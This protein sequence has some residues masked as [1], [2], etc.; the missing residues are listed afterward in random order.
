MEGEWSTQDVRERASWPTQVLLQTPPRAR[1][2]PDTKQ[3]NDGRRCYRCFF[4]T[5]DNL[6]DN[7]QQQRW[8]LKP[9][10]FENFDNDTKR[11]LDEKRKVLRWVVDKVPDLQDIEYC[12]AVVV[13][14][15]KDTL[16]EYKFLEDS[17]P[18]ENELLKLEKLRAENLSD[19]EK[20]T[21]CNQA[22]RL[23]EKLD[24]IFAESLQIGK[25]KAC[26]QGLANFSN[27]RSYYRDLIKQY[28]LRKDCGNQTSL[29]SSTSAVDKDSNETVIHTENGALENA[30]ENVA[31]SSR[32]SDTQGSRKQPSIA[33]SRSSRRRQIEEMELKNI[34]SQTE[35]EQRLRE[36]QLELEKEREEIEFRRQQEELRLQQQQQQ[37]QQD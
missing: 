9:K 32:H 19:S 15:P 11:M 14:Y 20:Q 35:T 16:Q 4:E 25:T 21:L 23:L 29:V 3:N 12:R 17:V 18:I 22:E 33:N 31:V 27:A 28:R 8:L 10:Y 5:F 1:S 6:E 24:K 36:R 34:R 30:E 13:D 2:L 26:P 7:R 37:Q